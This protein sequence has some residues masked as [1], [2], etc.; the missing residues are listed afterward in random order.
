MTDPDLHDPR[1]DS[2]Y[3]DTP[4]DEPPPEL[5]ERIRAAARRAVGAG[6]Q[7]LDGRIEAER[8]RS[9]VVRW[10]VP[11]SLAAT[12]VL[13]IT[14]ALMVQEEERRSQYDGPAP[15]A[16]APAAVEPPAPPPANE[17][18]IPREATP[19]TRS[20]P[21]DRARAAPAQRKMSEPAA[22]TAAPIAP[23]PVERQ[24][25]ASESAPQGLGVPS[26]AAS[27]PAPAP[28]PAPAIPGGAM[29][30]VPQAAPSPEVS[31]PLGSGGAPG[32]VSAPPPVSAPAPAIHDGAMQIAPRAAPS[33]DLPQPLSRERELSE[34]PARAVREGAP[35]AMP[36]RSPEEWVEAIRRLTAEGRTAEAAAELAEFRRRYPDYPLPP[37]LAR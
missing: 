20:K 22:S 9:F 1:L 29:R 12:V 4:R 13:V 6:P 5:D 34:R 10:R 36:S 11:L 30:S 24:E 21:A 14:L 25:R 26:G 27:T 35:A 23:S 19:P 8:P 15:V 31:Q 37:D 28:V 7:S 18:D 17:A 33:P 3:R 2:A 32:A 16:P